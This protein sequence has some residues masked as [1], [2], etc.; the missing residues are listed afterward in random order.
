MTELEHEHLA[1]ALLNELS[2]R[3]LAEKILL[4][5]RHIARLE[6]LARDEPGMADYI[7][8]MIQH[9]ANELLE[10]ERKRGWAQQIADS[11][12][13]DEYR[14][15]VERVKLDVELSGILG[16]PIREI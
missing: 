12:S 9:K 7:N 4:T 5:E 16:A 1:N 10:M 2:S 15:V 6:D 8:G 3:E 13:A 14:Q 11:S